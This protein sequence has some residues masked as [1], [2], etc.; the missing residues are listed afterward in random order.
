MSAIARARL[1]QTSK[2]IPCPDPAILTKTTSALK[3]ASLKIS[4]KIKTLTEQQHAGGILRDRE[5]ADVGHRAGQAGADLK[6]IPA[7]EL[8]Q[9]ML[10]ARLG[11]HS[12]LAMLRSS[13]EQ[14]VQV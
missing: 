12:R 14:L 1:E 2:Q 10:A 13:C 11:M 4:L 6:Q 9:G 8:P 5:P 3:C 7:P